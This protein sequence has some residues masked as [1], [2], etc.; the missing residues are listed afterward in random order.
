LKGKSIQESK[1]KE[2]LRILSAIPRKLTQPS[3]LIADEGSQ[4]K[5]RFLSFDLLIGIGVFPILQITSKV[6]DGIP[7]YSGYAVLFAIVYLISRTQHLRISTAITI[8]STAALPFTILIIHQ[9]WESTNLA[10]Q[11]LIWPV[12]AALIGSQLLSME[13]EA[14][15][16]AGMNIGLIIV[17]WTHPGILFV[18]AIQ[19]IAASFALQALLWLTAWIEEFYRTKLEIANQNLAARGRELEIY[20]SLLRHDLGNDIQMVLGGIE[21]SQMTCDD[22]KKQAAFLEST[23]AAAERMRSLIHMFSLSES[24][25]DAD[26]LKVLE[27]IGKRASIAFKGMEIEIVA[28]EKVKRNPPHYGRLTAVAFENLFRNCSQHAG[29]NP[30]VHIDL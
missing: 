12:I 16:I 1:S 9:N 5:A 19:F 26:I 28:T 10:F 14:L 29:E 24:E 2:G 6:T 8:I 13:K 25:L 11:I 17:A 7:Y 23:L 18:E 27:T 15:L 3:S 21:L 20:T 22:E 30:P 4:R